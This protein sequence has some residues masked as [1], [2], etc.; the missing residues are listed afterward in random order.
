MK[1]Q[2]SLDEIKTE[3]AKILLQFVIMLIA[4]L[5]LG[6]FVSKLLSEETRQGAFSMMLEHFSSRAD[7]GRLSDMLSSFLRYSAFDVISFIIIFV[8]SFSFINYI[9]SDIILVLYGAKLGLSSSLIISASG[10]KAFDTVLF[11]IFK[12]I[13]VILIALY[14]YKMALLALDIR[15]FSSKGRYLS[16]SKKTLAMLTVSLVF[17]GSILLINGLYCLFIYI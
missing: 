2:R 15:R 6:I 13:V 17:I 16:N 8:F 14:C 3:K 1:I 9:V 12:P 5:M 11:F 7:Q 4:S 10:L